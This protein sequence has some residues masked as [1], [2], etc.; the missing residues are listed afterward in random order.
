[1][2]D[3]S[4]LIAT[5]SIAVVGK[6]LAKSTEVTAT[7]TFQKKY[8]SYRYFFKKVTCNFEVTSYFFK[9]VRVTTNHRLFS[10]TNLLSKHKCDITIEVSNT[11]IWQKDRLLIHASTALSVNKTS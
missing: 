5:F 8:R 11:A 2:K 6:L 9:K 4:Y 3:I 7:G 1:M 10:T